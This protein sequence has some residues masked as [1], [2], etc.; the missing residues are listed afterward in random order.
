MDMQTAKVKGKFFT[1][2]RDGAPVVHT[3]RKYLT[4]R[5]AESAAKCWVAFHGEK[6]S[7]MDSIIKPG[8]TFK[9]RANLTHEW[10]AVDYATMKATLDRIAG[11]VVTATVRVAAGTGERYIDVHN[12]GS[13]YGQYFWTN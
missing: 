4:R 10:K 12:G 13:S 11:S 7:N 9:V 2:V 1:V 3:T 6:D 8:D 5:M